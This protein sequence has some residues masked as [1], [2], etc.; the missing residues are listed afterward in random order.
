MTNKWLK[1]ET[2][3]LKFNGKEYVISNNYT[4]IIN[5]TKNQNYR[6]EIKNKNAHIDVTQEFHKKIQ[7]AFKDNLECMN[8]I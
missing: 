7:K 2:L 5:H 3:I 6:Y 8:L 1:K 4:F